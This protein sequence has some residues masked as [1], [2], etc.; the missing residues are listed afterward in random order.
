MRNQNL[1]NEQEKTIWNCAKDI[2]VYDYQ[3]YK[4]C[5]SQYNNKN[6]Y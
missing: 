2:V 3:A 5:S 4:F 1:F 6:K